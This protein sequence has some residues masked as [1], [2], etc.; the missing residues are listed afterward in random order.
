MLRRYLLSTVSP[1]VNAEEAKNLVR[2]AHR[3]A[4]GV[5]QPKS[6]QGHASTIGCNCPSPDVLLA[7]CPWHGSRAQRI[8]FG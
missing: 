8:C 6:E 7:N 2:A 3:F 5:I 1:H 4:F